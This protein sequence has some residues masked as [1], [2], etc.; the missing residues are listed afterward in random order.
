MDVKWI[1]NAI[2]DFVSRKKVDKKIELMLGDKAIDVITNSLQ[3]DRKTIRVVHATR[4]RA[5]GE[6]PTAG[7]QLSCFS[8]LNIHTFLFP[9]NIGNYHWITAH[10]DR[11]TK[12]AT[13][14]DS[15]GEGLGKGMEYIKTILDRNSKSFGTGWK[16]VA[17]RCQQQT[18]ATSCGLFTIRM[19]EFL[20][21]SR[22]SK[23]LK[24]LWHATGEQLREKY[25]R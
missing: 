4:A 24:K 8:D 14:Y 15:A 9:V 2:I 6:R 25:A 12:C 21:K 23:V 20:V 17:A 11:R 22:P 19:I 3:Y 18:D 1:S 10:L 7:Q 16:H 13:Y 5:E